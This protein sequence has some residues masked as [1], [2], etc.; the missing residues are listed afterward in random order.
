MCGACKPELH[1]RWL[2]LFSIMP[3]ACGIPQ[4]GAEPLPVAIEVQS[5]NHWSTREVQILITW[6]QILF[7]DKLYKVST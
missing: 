6:Q 5:L 1:I 4:P 7:L 2:I 3:H